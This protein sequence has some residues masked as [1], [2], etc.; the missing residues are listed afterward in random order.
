MIIQYDEYKSKLNALRPDLKSLGEALR[1]EDA[2]RE[3]DE[4]EQKSAAD[5]FWNDL[6]NSQKVLKRL[7]QLNSKCE[8][9]EKLS[10]TLEDLFTL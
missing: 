5:G 2:H 1:M 9:Y 4:L 7:K 3:I 8:K 10:R 6:E